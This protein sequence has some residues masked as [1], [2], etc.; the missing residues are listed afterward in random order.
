MVK[1]LSA[2]RRK[3]GFTMVELVVVIAII[4][5]LAGIMAVSMLDRNNAKIREANINASAFMSA[6]QLAMTRIQFTEREL[7]KGNQNFLVYKDGAM[8]MIDDG[9]ASTPN[10][11]YLFIEMKFMG[12]GAVYLHLDSSL[13]GLMSKSETLGTAPL[14][15]YVSNAISINLTD[16]YDGYFYAAVDSDFRV[17]CTHFS[18][19]RLPVS[20][21]SDGVS[22]RDKLLFTAGGVI[23]GIVVGSCSDEY[24]IAPAGAYAFCAPANGTAEA[25]KYYKTASP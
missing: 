8:Q 15:Q 9:A 16:S 4:A 11:I 21:G 2:L 1:Y 13:N 22:Y 20:T 5:V 24:T 14:E 18:E 17:L 25:S 19:T 12:N 6:T 23:D 7:V 10:K 3:K